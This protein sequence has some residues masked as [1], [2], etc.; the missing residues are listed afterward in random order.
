MEQSAKEAQGQVLHSNVFRLS[1]NFGKRKVWNWGRTLFFAPTAPLKGRVNS[2]FI[3]FGFGDLEGRA[4]K[5]KRPNGAG[6]RE[7]G[8]NQNTVPLH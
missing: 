6:P 5:A 1:P 4:H 3:K 2:R 7:A 8:S